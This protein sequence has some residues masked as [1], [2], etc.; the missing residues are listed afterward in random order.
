MWKDILSDAAMWLSCNM[1]LAVAL[2]VTQRMSVL[3][4]LV[5]PALVAL[6]KNGRKKDE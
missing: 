5:I 4:F 2:N 3:W 6:S 1:V